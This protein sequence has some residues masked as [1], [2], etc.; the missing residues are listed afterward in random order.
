[1]KI[2]EEIEGRKNSQL[3]SHK[4]QHESSP[5]KQKQRNQP[6]SQ[7]EKRRVR[8]CTEFSWESLC[9]FCFVVDE[10]QSGSREVGQ[11]VG[12]SRGTAAS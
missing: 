3:E 10:L 7:R 1:M 2:W 8:V 4:T 11:S 9:G 5:M 12:F 6:T